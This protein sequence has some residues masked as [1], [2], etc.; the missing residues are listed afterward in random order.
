N[1]TAQS[2]TINV[3]STATGVST[4]VNAK[5]GN[6]TVTVGNA[7][8]GLGSLNGPLTLDGGGQPNDAL[9]LDD[10]NSPIGHTYGISSAGVTRDGTS[11]LTSFSGFTSLTLNASNQA[12][13]INVP[14]TA[15]GLATKV[16]GKGGNDTI[17]V[18]NAS[19]GLGD[20]AGA[21]VVDGGGQAGDALNLNDQA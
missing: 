16:N 14:S 3:L 4:T 12:D 9:I 13:T 11:V 2:D 18:G 6:D 21:L 19:T 10:Q 15:A 1:A 20:L 17:N 8:N 5:G 7:S